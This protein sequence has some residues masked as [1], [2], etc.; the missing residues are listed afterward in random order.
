M[1]LDIS[2]ELAIAYVHFYV[3]NLPYWQRWFQKFFALEPVDTQ[4]FFPHLTGQDVLLRSPELQFVL[5]APHAPND[6]VDQYLKKHPCG[7]ADIAFFVNPAIILNLDLNL[8]SPTKV[9][10]PVGFQHTLIPKQNIPKSNQN[11]DHLV[12]NVAKGSLEKIRDWYI[13]KLGFQPKQSFQIQTEYS[14]LTSQVLQHSSGIQIPINQPGDRRSQIQEFLDY[15][16]GAGIQHIAIKQ[17]NLPEKILHLQRQSLSFLDVPQTYYQNLLR[18]YPFLKNLSQWSNIQRAKILVDVVRSPEEIL[19]Q[20]FTQP[21]FKEPTFFWEFIERK[22]GATGF[23]EG[24]FQA[25][26][27]AIETAQKQRVISP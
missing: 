7:V 8:S 17:N 18:E 14:G 27:E 15:N 16:R 25:L 12:L 1:V 20:I 19:M 5:S 10:N 3:D 26:F 13:H 21:I 4:H 2:Q 22:Q 9:I 24:N 11:I 6:P 23:G